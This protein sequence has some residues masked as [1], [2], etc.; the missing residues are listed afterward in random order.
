MDVDHVSSLL[1]EFKTGELSLEE[2]VEKLKILP[3][4]DLEF[5]KL[6]H[7]RLIRQ[8]F[9]EVVFCQGKTVEQVQAIVQRLA[10]Y[11]HSILATRASKEMYTAVKAVVADAEYHELAR[12]IT[13]ERQKPP[14]D[15]ERFILVMSAGTSD[16]PVAEEAAVT[17]EIMGN[18]VRRVYDVGVAGIHRL[19]D[20][21]QLI[22]QA[23]VLIV[24]AG[25][26]GALASVVGGM[27][28]KPVI[29]V[30]TSIGYGASFG[31]LAALL[32][33]LNSCA[34]GIAVVNIDNGFGAG[35]LASIINQ[36]R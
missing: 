24:V 6:D 15:S 20:Q 10:E 23:N 28:A 26:E 18:E 8:G 35:R 27:A 31:G 1:R 3:Y 32:S 25:M 13:V 30:P 33:M 5:A 11:N 9:A 16:I 2:T 7:H 22:E 29:A 4:E 17:A 19:L 14:V 36:M 12:L 21:R 34:A